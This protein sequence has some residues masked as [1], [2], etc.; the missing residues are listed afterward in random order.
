VIYP[1]SQWRGHLPVGHIAKL[2]QVFSVVPRK[3]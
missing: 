2:C 3:N 1:G